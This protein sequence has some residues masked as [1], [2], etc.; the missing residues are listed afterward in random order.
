MLIFGTAN[1]SSADR[2]PKA[3]RELKNRDARVVDFNPKLKAHLLDMKARS[4]NVSQWFSHHPNEAKRTFLQRHFVN[5]WCWFAS[6]P[7][8]QILDFTIAGIILFQCAS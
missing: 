2:S 1:F 8:C 5:R 3:N 7:K 6:A 4:H